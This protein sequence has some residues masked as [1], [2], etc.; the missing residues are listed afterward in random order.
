MTAYVDGEPRLTISLSKPFEVQGSE[1]YRH[2][3]VGCGGGK[4]TFEGLVDEV[5]LVRRALQPS[6]FLSFSRPPSGLMLIVR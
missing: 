1:P 6:E 4:Q 5:R 2:F 3:F